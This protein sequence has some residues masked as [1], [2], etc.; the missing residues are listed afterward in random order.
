[1]KYSENIRVKNNR[2]R[3][4]PRYVYLYIDSKKKRVLSFISICLAKK[5]N[6]KIEYNWFF[7]IK[8]QILDITQ[9]IYPTLFIGLQHI[10]WTDW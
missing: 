9:V 2:G 7:R 6:F 4:A 8:V 1:M 5:N 10:F 3:G